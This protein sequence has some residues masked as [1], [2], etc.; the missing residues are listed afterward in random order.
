[1]NYKI[2]R[3]ST[4]KITE[5]KKKRNK[6]MKRRGIKKERNFRCTNFLSLAAV[7]TLTD[8]KRKEYSTRATDI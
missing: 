2:G 6:E 4:T 7:W 5:G 1:M 8:W 3:K